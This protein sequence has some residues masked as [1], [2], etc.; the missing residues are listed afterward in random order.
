MEHRDQ[1]CADC[2]PNLRVTRPLTAL[3]KAR[4]T[5]AGLCDRFSPRTKSVIMTSPCCDALTESSHADLNTARLAVDS[6]IDIATFKSS[7]RCSQKSRGTLTGIA[8][9]TTGT[10]NPRFVNRG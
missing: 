9:L 1:D 10:T 4:S 3:R 7:V 2:V 8:A 6:R 5:S